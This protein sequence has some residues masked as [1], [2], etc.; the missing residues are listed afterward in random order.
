MTPAQLSLAIDDHELWLSSR[1]L[2]GKK[3]FLENTR[4]RDA[5]FT[6]KDLSHASFAGTHFTN[7]SFIDC[8]LSFLYAA[9]CQWRD[10]DISGSKLTCISLREGILTRCDFTGCD[11]YFATMTDALFKSC[12][13]DKTLLKNANLTNSKL[14]NSPLDRA[15]LCDTILTGSTLRDAGTASVHHLTRGIIKR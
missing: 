9:H 4:I 12:T 6:G 8:A 2:E 15:Y 1:G 3:L 11:M 5:H 14:T 10:V 7:V 13:F